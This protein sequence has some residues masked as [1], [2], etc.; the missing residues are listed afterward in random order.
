MGGVPI[1]VALDHPTGAEARALYAQLA[2][3]N[4]PVKIGNELFTREGPA[5]VRDFVGRGAPV[6]LDLKYHDIPNT[7]AAACRAAADL[8][9]WMINVHVSGGRE[10]LL[11]A[12]DALA[13]STPRPLLVGVTLLTSLDAAELGRLGVEPDPANQVARLTRL[14]QACGL[15]GVVCSP[16]EIALVKAACGPDFITVTPG[17]RSAGIDPGDQRRVATPAQAIRAGGDY[18]V[19]GRPITH[20]KDPRAAL[21]QIEHEIA[22]TTR[23]APRA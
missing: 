17:I 16:Q 12:R 8:G 3:T 13:A 1:I 5:I 10:M 2:R 14:A 11:A 22:E 6:F 7:V 23:L 18:L 21:G 9:V 4:V 15:D 19:I 20:A